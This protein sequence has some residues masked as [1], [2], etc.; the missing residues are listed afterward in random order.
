[1]EVGRGG[2]AL[3]AALAFASHQKR[4]TAE[5]AAARNRYVAGL[6]DALFIAYAAPGGKTEALAREAL[7]AGEPVLHLR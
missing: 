5:L 6:A 2:G 1:M 3:A 4:M 7:A